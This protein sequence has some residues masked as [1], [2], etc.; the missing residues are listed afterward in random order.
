MLYF[1]GVALDGIEDLFSDR[2]RIL[3]LL[4]DEQ[5]RLAAA[6]QLRWDLCMQYWTRI[7]TFGSG[8]WPLED[9]PWRTSDG[10]ES[11]HFSLL[12]ASIVI[13]G[14]NVKHL[15]SR[16][17]VR[18]TA[19]LEE[20]A[21]RGRITRR[22]LHDDAA[23]AVHVPGTRLRLVG[24]ESL[25]PLQAWPVSSFSSLLLKRVL[26]LTAQVEHTRDRER[27]FE[28]ADQTW[29]HVLSRRLSSST[30]AGLWDQPSGAWPGV[31]QHQH[32]SWYHTQR[33]CECLVVAAGTLQRRG[34][35]SAQLIEL[36][37]EYLA[38][39]E[40]VF[41][42]ERLFGTWAVGRRFAEPGQE[43]PSESIAARLER[44]RRL[45]FERPGT[46]IVLAMEV[47]RDLDEVARPRAQTLTGDYQ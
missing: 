26:Q 28:L 24:S 37:G 13:Q 16:Q 30:G 44:A 8:R 43:T 14:R 25:G 41:D 36:A 42:Q 18:L 35:V 6:L 12:V 40:Y 10:I 39:A 21:N 5:Q 1:T 4:D 11:D 32:P 2:T 27:V 9:L 7:A 19:V 45:Q 38:E 47:L 3:G 31:P 29:D 23:L 34:P 33:V 46:S 15:V 17:A 22:P 20:L